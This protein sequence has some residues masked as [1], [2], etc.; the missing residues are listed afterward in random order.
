MNELSG[1]EHH[2][3]SSTLSGFL[4]HRH[5]GPTMD[6]QSMEEFL[7]DH[8]LAPCR[9]LS[10][11]LFVCSDRLA[12]LTLHDSLPCEP[13]VGCMIKTSQR[14]KHSRECSLCQNT[15]F[16]IHITI[17]LNFLHQRS[18]MIRSSVLRHFPSCP[19][20]CNVSATRSY[21][22]PFVV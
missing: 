22:L 8:S 3:T 2:H 15:L 19:P 16:S 9:K 13:P 1:L 18:R 10:F 12:M 7:N 14:K 6:A 5:K 17:Q 20:C 4:A 11:C 21:L